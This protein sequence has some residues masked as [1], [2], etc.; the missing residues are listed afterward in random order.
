[1]ASPTTNLPSGPIPGMNSIR[2]FSVIT[3]SLTRVCSSAA[4]LADSSASANMA[5]YLCNLTF[6]TTSV[7]PNAYQAES[8]TPFL[9]NCT[10]PLVANGQPELIEL[11][12]NGTASFGVGVT[13]DEETDGSSVDFVRP[14]YLEMGD[15]PMGIVVRKGE[16]ARD[17]QLVSSIQAGLVST[18]WGKD[19]SVA[20]Q[21]AEIDGANTQPLKFPV[22]AVSGFLT[23]GGLSL[24]Y[25]NTPQPSGSLQTPS[26]ADPVDVTVA[27]YRGDALPLANITGDSIDQWSGI[28]VE[29]I[30]SICATPGP[31][32]CVDIITVDTLDDRL[33]VVNNGTASISI[34]E[35]VV[36]QSRLDTTNFVQPFY[37]SAGPGLYVLE[38]DT[39]LYPADATL[40]VMNGK[41]VCTITDSAWN[42]VAESYGAQLVSFDTRAEADKAVE[43]GTC[44]GLLWDSPVR[45]LDSFVY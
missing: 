33:A 24:S 5:S 29:M 9:D 8:F 44:I 4:I 23:E 38:E 27:V 43:D 28:E 34:G 1:M 39:S 15:G 45:W 17:L 3:L 26:R 32:N 20:G 35:I 21:I 37:Y 25:K 22:A 2:G 31:L 41:P 42:P 16:R 10:A 36:T 13:L 18:L 7:A 40:D 6:A 12:Q 11:V 14:F 30:N 19:R